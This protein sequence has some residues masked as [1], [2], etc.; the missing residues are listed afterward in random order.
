M[1]GRN[2]RGSLTRALVAFSAAGHLAL[3]AWWGTYLVQLISPEVR[4]RQPA[5]A[6]APGWQGQRRRQQAQGPGLRWAPSAGSRIRPCARAARPPPPCGPSPGTPASSR[7]AAP[8][9]FRATS[10]HSGRLP[11]PPPF[12]VNA[13]H[14]QWARPGRAPSTNDRGAAVPRSTAAPRDRLRARSDRAGF[15]GL[16]RG[17]WVIISSEAGGT[18]ARGQRHLPAAQHPVAARG[19]DAGAWH[20]AHSLGKVLAGQSHPTRADGIAVAFT[21]PAGPAF[22]LL[23]SHGV[24]R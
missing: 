7:R 9:N 19:V 16:E 24:H 22:V 8:F 17:R 15:Q 12:H 3:R 5:A 20:S 6:P 14:S 18:G 2:Q 13:P 23:F 1:C 21:R 4:R 11:R 10:P